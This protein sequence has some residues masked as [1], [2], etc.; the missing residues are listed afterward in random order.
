MTHWDD[1]P[2][3][4]ENRELEEES[5]SR[6]RA[7]ISG[8]DQFLV[9]SE[10]A[11]DYGTDFWIEARDGREPKNVRVAVQLKG[12][13]REANADGSVSRSVK[14][15]TLNYLA[16]NPASVFVCYHEPSH[17]LLVRRVDDI[18]REYEHSRG[19][20]GDQ[21]TVT[22]RFRDAFTE[23]FQKELKDYALASATGARD[24]RRLYAT[25]P[26]DRL[27]GLPEEQGVELPVPADAARAE[28][29]LAELYRRGQDRTISCNFDKFRA[30]LGGSDGRLL[31][32]YLAEINLG[33]NGQRV[34][35]E[36]I[37]RG[38]E[39]LEAAVAGGAFSPGSMLYCVGNGWLALEQYR[40]AAKEYETALEL[41]DGSDRSGLTACCLKNLGAAKEKLGDVDGAEDLYRKALE[42]DGD[43]AEAHFALARRYS[44]GPKVTGGLERALEHLDAIMCSGESAVTQTSVQGWRAEILFKLGKT[45]EAFRDVQA[46]QGRDQEAEWVLPW[47]A[48][49]VATY[50]RVSAEAERQSLR[51]WDACARKDPRRRFALD[52]ERERL[53]CA[54]RIHANGE[55]TP[56]SYEEVRRS[57]E[58][59]V[60]R[61][62]ADPAFLWDRCGH[63]AQD[64]GDW[65]EAE[66]CYRRA[67]ELSPDEYGYCLGT[68]LN[69]LGRYREALP[70]LLPQAKQHQ[71]DALSWFQVAVASEGTGDV[72]GTV[73]AYR[74]ALKFDED[75]AR[76]WFNLGGVYWNS[77]RVTEARSTWK[78]AVRRFPA[79]EAAAEIRANVPGLLTE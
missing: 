11:A 74:R 70:I 68:A 1:F 47:C 58:Q 12:T 51:F 38:I 14:R 42:L 25:L 77:G 6:F 65:V 59:M 33:V 39:I 17:S 28:G 73:D 50:G 75:Y 66:A 2:K 44:R 21:A 35:K 9:Q 60:A 10:D 48:K 31:H 3:L 23:E 8:S 36:R 49:L 40:K 79:H 56:Y 22:V 5:K 13:R 41:F 24:R 43:L 72:E 71:P 53:L 4:D 16:M 32:A 27:V 78:E 34:D 37:L 57:V 19:Y 26:P 67:V 7:A 63:W 45:V 61:G 18:V 30:V 29:L 62:A 55:Q 64:D 15:T 20:L 76:A 69:F 52:A 54:F 46:L